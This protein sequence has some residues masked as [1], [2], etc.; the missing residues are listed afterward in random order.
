MAFSTILNSFLVSKGF[1]IAIFNSFNFPPPSEWRT[2]LL[3]IVV[4]SVVDLAA[5]AA[6][7]DVVAEAAGEVVAAAGDAVGAARRRRSGS[8]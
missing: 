1:H 8:R 7:A 6:E 3:P 2:L 4:D 5:V